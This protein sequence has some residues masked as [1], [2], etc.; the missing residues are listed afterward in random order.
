MSKS[1]NIQ[2]GSKSKNEFSS[3]LVIKVNVENLVCHYTLG[4]QDAYVQSAFLQKG[5]IV[6]KTVYPI[7]I[8]L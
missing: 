8:I 1:L 7:P 5:I 2:K 4:Y 3:G 6:T